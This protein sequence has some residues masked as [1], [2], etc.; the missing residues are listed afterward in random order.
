MIY[1][2]LKEP[3]TVLHYSYIKSKHGTTMIQT[4]AK[5]AM[6]ET[7]SN[8]ICKLPAREKCW[9]AKYPAINKERITPSCLRLP[10]AIRCNMAII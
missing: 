2:L 7:W 1:R 4:M 8:A 9:K 6:M 5:V 3:L 10:W